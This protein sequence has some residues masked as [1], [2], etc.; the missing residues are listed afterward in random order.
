MTIRPD[1]TGGL[2]LEEDFQSGALPALWASLPRF[3]LRAGDVFAAPDEVDFGQWFTKRLQGQM[4]SCQGVTIAAIGGA[5]AGL[6]TGTKTVLSALFAYLETQR[7]DGLLGG[8]QGSTISN[9]AKL[10][11]E[12]GICREQFAPYPNPVVYPRRWQRTQQ[13]LDDAADYRCPRQQ[14][15]YSAQECFDWLATGQGLISTGTMF[16]WYP[17]SD[18]VVRTFTPRGGGHAIPFRGYSHKMKDRAGRPAFRATNSWPWGIDQDG[19]ITWDALN[20]AFEHR[21][22][23]I[24]GVAIDEVEA[25]RPIDFTQYDLMA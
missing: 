15:L 11:M 20:R 23:A 12:V 6:R 18:G 24:W 1:G 3:T 17:D 19:W 8:D 22:T 21:Y 14:P 25:H 10:L 16:G 2:L 4:G 13:Q 7:L 5:L 9:G